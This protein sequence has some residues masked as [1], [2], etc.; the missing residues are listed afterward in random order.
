MVLPT[1]D[2]LDA[3][4]PEVLKSSGKPRLKDKCSVAQLANLAQAKRVHILL[5]GETRRKKV[6]MSIHPGKDFKGI[7][8]SFAGLA[9]CQCHGV[10]TSTCHFNDWLCDAPD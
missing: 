6:S 7:T 10:S 1:H 8:F 2:V 9:T 4:L 3:P 5:C